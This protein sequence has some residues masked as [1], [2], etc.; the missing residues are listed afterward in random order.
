MRRAQNRSTRTQ[1]GAQAAPNTGSVS[2]TGENVSS[3]G[4]NVS[5]TG[6]NAGA[7]STS[8]RDQPVSGAET[9]SSTSYA[10]GAPQPTYREAG[11]E[12]TTENTGLGGAMSVLTGLLA[13][14]FGLAMVEKNHFYPS[15][16]GYAYRISSGNVDYWGWIMIGLG[17]L[18]FAAGACYALGLPFGRAA[19]VAFA[20]LTAVGGF[21]ALVFSPFWGFIIVAL[22]VVTL[23]ALLRRNR[24]GGYG[25]RSMR[26]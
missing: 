8:L 4:Q 26:M 23:W 1:S 21:L 22:S 19:A 25:S 9:T 24:S 16:P 17:I 12:E 14:L 20:V 15:L 7:T 10:R 6:A 3:T 18:L 2:G 5:G 11:P 13:F